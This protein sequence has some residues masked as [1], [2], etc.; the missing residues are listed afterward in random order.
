IMG[1]SIVAAAAVW[2]AFRTPRR[3]VAALALTTIVI[4]LSTPVLRNA[5]FIVALPQPLEAY[6]RPIP[7][8]TNFVL[9]PWAAF[10]FAGAVAGVLLDH[11]RA[12]DQ[13]TR[14]N[15]GLGAAGLALA[16]LAL[17]ASYLPSPYP[18]SYF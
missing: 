9:L 5:P 16:A 2:G 12:R 18:H 17:G 3:R 8:M 1:P 7:G 15:I 13:E 4:A 10:V 11:V 14:V 6:F